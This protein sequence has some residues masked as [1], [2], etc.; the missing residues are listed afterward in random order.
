MNWSGEFYKN[1]FNRLNPDIKFELKQNDYVIDDKKC[2]GNAQCISL[3]GKA[4]IPCSF[5]QHKNDSSHILLV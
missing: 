5:Q 3:C 4:L 1:I 2:A